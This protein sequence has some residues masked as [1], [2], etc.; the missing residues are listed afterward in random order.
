MI[1]SFVLTGASWRWSFWLYTILNG[2]ALV[3][4]ILFLDE[5]YFNRSIPVA[6]R[7]EPQPR[8]KALLGLSQ[9]RTRWSR[10]TFLSALARPF[11]AMPKI[12]FLLTLIYCYVNYAW[13][14]GVN[15]TSAIWLTT[16]YKFTPVNLGCFYFAALVGVGLGTLGGH[17]AHDAVGAAW[18]KRHDGI[19]QPEARLILVYPSSVLMAVSLII[20]GFA[21][22]RIWQYMIIAVSI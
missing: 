7:P 10:T 19:I 6:E 17:W 14:I 3:L 13:L 18:A 21:L 12:P 8:W 16:I 4:V 9:W 11:L 2:I 22:E 5:P 15:T 1:A 20:L